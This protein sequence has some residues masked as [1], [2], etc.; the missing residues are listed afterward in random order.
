M[1]YTFGDSFTK[2]IW[3]TW[4]DW[5][6][7]YAECTVTNLAYSGYNNQFIYQ[8][9]L[10]SVNGLTTHDT[11]YIMWNGG[12]QPWSWYDQEWIDQNDC[13]GFFPSPDGNMHFTNTPWQGMWRT[14]P[15][16][17]PSLTEM[18]INDVDIFF[19]TQMLLDRVG[20]N[21]WMMFGK[22]PWLDVRATY[23]PVYKRDVPYS[24]INS[25][26]KNRAQKI[27]AMA[28]VKN[29]LSMIDWN[30]WIC[31]PKDPFDPAQYTGLWEFMLDEKESF[32]LNNPEMGHPNPLTHHDFTTQYLLN[33]L[34]KSV[35]I[36]H[37]NR[38]EK[39]AQ[40]A[41][42]MKVPEWDPAQSLTGFSEKI[43]KKW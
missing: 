20:C 23:K 38:A 14:H 29:T 37:R 15:D 35:D 42:D 41:L 39:S 21:Y 4:S 32:L 6:E 19:K 2:W 12:S 28:P 22:N 26:D 13:R 31:A 5:L 43:V 16:N 18:L 30:H 27:M 24:K 9:L 7:E 34:N 36:I 8:Q 1:I 25:K 33:T 17:M 11:V 40:S 10:E 3:P